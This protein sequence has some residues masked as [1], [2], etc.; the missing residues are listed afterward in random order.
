MVFRGRSLIFRGVCHLSCGNFQVT[1]I[2]LYKTF[3]GSRASG[4]CQEAD[5]EVWKFHPNQCRKFVGLFVFIQH[6]KVWWS[7]LSGLVDF[8]FIFG[9]GKRREF[10]SNPITLKRLHKKH[11]GPIFDPSEKLSS[12]HSIRSWPSSEGTTWDPCEKGSKKKRTKFTGDHRGSAAFLRDYHKDLPRFFHIP[13]PKKRI[14]CPLEKLTIGYRKITIFQQE[15]HRP[16][17]GPFSSQLRSLR[18]GF[19]PEKIR[20]VMRWSFKKTLLPKLTGLYPRSKQAFRNFQQKG[21]G[22]S[23]NSPGNMLKWQFLWQEEVLNAS[24]WW[25]SHHASNI[26]WPFK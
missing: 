2:C 20:Q 21:S 25:I 9:W 8:L 10:E 18:L 4:S 12:A 23:R 22:W 14:I 7:E 3:W 17:P 5:V 24:E 1:V 26:C 6:P 19:P 16:I 15:I 13:N 11:C